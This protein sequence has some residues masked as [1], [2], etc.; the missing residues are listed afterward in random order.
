MFF[1]WTRRAPSTELLTILKFHP[2][3]GISQNFRVS[4]V[5]P[6]YIVEDHTLHY[7]E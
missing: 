4:C 2:Q 5:K 7:L 3:V 6:D 1:I